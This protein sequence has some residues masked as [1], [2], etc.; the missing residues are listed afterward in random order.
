MP[1]TDY[2][3]TCYTRIWTLL[4]ASSDFTTAVKPGNRR[5]LDQKLAQPFKMNE[6]SAGFP[7]FSLMMGPGKRDMF[8]KTTVFQTFKSGG[9]CDSYQDCPQAYDLFIVHDIP[10]ITKTNAMKAIVEAALFLGGPTLGVAKLYK[11]TLDWQ[12]D[13]LTSRPVCPGGD[14][15]GVTR[16]IQQCRINVTFRT[17]GA[18]A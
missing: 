17:H 15:F 8:T 11:W 9:P 18:L 2:L 3:T 7:Q 10:D 1:V 4:E 6:T 12:A 16:Y 5:R 14:P 13:K